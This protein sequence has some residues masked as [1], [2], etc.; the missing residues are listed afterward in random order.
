MNILLSLAVLL[1]AQLTSES[2]S[3]SPNTGAKAKKGATVP[4]VKSDINKS[5]TKKIPTTKQTKADADP[6]VSRDGLLMMAGLY[7]N[8]AD[9]K[10]PHA[11]PL[12]GDLSGL[13][14]IL[15]QVGTAETLLDDSIRIT[16][17]ARKAGVAIELQQFEDLVHVF[18]A[19]A[20]VPEA[21]EA[22]EKLGAFLKRHL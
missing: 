9:P 21:L 20:P 17:R 12:Y 11:A 14:P 4:T 19:F 7:L 16:E 5:G 13:P 2:K 10:H 18:Q 8:G 6:M 22:I 1:M 15:V 3:P